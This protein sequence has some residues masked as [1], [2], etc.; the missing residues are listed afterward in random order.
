MQVARLDTHRSCLPVF[1]VHRRRCH[2]ARFRSKEAAGVSKRELYWK[3]ARRTLIIFA[4]GIFLAGFPYSIFRQF[5]FQCPATHRRLLSL[6]VAH[7]FEYESRNTNHHRGRLPL[8]Y[9]LLMTVFAARV[10]RRDLSKEGSVASYIDR[11]VFG[12][13]ICVREKFYDHEGLLSTIPAIATTLFEFWPANCCALGRPPTRSCGLFVCRS[14][15]RGDRMDLERIFRLTNH[16]GPA[17]TCSSR[18]A[19]L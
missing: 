19:W 14:R 18:V 8:L 4:L 6:R 5:V 9:W 1:S 10:L 15:L 13:H 2:T 17:L 12:A 16:C 3:I 11:A 7:F